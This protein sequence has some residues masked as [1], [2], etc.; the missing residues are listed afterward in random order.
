[1]DE[2]NETTTP[3]SD[4]V[5]DDQ[6]SASDSGTDLAAL[7]SSV[8]KLEDNNARLTVDL[9][10]R[11]KSIKS[12]QRERN[13]KNVADQTVKDKA[14]EDQGEWKARFESQ[15]SQN[16][17]TA[18][19]SQEKIN[20]LKKSLHGLAVESVI[21]DAATQANAY[22][23]SQFVD[24]FASLFRVG[25]DST[26]AE[27][28]PEAARSRGLEP[29]RDGNLLS[30]SEFISALS[31]IEGYQNLF[32]APTT[33]GAGPRSASP[34]NVKSIPSGDFAKLSPEKQQEH[35]ENLY[36]KHGVAGGAT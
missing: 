8:K 26:E 29:Y 35:L 24:L 18:K 36:D 34:T 2:K 21:R 33:G 7:E 4:Q 23:P 10:E 16:E 9:R 27:L 3:E 17:A 11:D 13:T 25:E 31:S 20:S 6:A 19:E 22:N 32:R 5:V 12:M 28:D 30:P 15:Q 14:L 1:M